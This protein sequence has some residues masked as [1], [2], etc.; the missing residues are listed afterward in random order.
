MITGGNEIAEK[1]AVVDF[2]TAKARRPFPN[3]PC[4]GRTMGSYFS[5]SRH[6]HFDHLGAGTAARSSSKISRAQT[7]AV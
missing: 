4:G 1:P 5:S 3:N 6:A 7:S 2:L